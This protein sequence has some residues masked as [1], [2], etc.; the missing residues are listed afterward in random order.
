MPF[1]EVLALASTVHMA[2]ASETERQHWIAERL[3]QQ[4][5]PHAPNEQ[6]QPDGRVIQITERRTP[7]AGLV[8]AYHDVTDL[9]QAGAEIE[10]LA[11]YD[12]LTH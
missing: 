8:I 7:D 2:N 4:L 5:T 6:I 11:F 12:A 10:H 3:A 9:R 1:S